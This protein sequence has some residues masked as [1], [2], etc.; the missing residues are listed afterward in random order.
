MG[1]QGDAASVVDDQLR[2]HGME[3]LRIVDASIMPAVPSA[4]ISAAVF[5]IAE[6]ASDMILGRKPLS[7]ME[8]RLVDAAKLQT[9]VQAA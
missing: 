6:K 9:V 5:M 8:P 4:N 3:G 2:V 7:T 1:P